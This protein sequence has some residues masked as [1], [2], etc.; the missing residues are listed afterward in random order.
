MSDSEPASNVAEI[1]KAVAALVH[2]VPV[3]QDAIQ[4]AAKELGKSLETIS[5]AINVA[6]S[7]VA[8]M[9]WSYEKI[10]S[11]IQESLEQKLANVPI[12]KII[13][14]KPHIA[15]PTIEALRYT[16]TEPDL[17]SLYAELL[18]TSMNSDTSTLAHPSFVDLIKNLSADEA[19]LIAVLSPLIGGGSFPIIEL[20]LEK[21]PAFSYKT[22]Q[23]NI[24]LLAKKANCDIPE[25]S[26]LYLSNLERLGVLNLSYNETLAEESE[27]TEIE[28]MEFV[29]QF[30]ARPIGPDTFR[31]KV[32][33]GVAFI[34]PV[35]AA[36]IRACAPK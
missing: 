15:V 4:P 10:K 33:R 24:H 20:R 26:A 36:F 17:A 21:P 13:A 16:G 3:Y 11:F 6:L 31:P 32:K 28:A 12:D 8:G 23:T 35:G 9:I 14:P 34:T 30:L 7:P 25:N 18:A 19:K 22:S 27:Y 29:K 2:E 5:K 1:T